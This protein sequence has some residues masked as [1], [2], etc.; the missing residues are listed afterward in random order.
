MARVSRF[1]KVGREVTKVHAPTDCA[2]SSYEI[3]GQ[4]YLQ[5]DTFGT[6]G[7]VLKGK[8]SQ[9]LQ[10]DE[11]AIRELLAIIGQSFPNLK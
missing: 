3:D 11:D 10:F 1:E 6:K 2:Y 9:S 5:L 4:K 8:V 7:R